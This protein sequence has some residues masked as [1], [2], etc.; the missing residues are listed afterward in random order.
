M[1]GSARPAA[2][3]S[4]MTIPLERRVSPKRPEP[5]RVE[6]AEKRT[7][8]HNWDS[9]SDS[10]DE[11]EATRRAFA[12][13]KVDTKDEKAFP[14]LGG[15]K[16]P[17]KASS[18]TKGSPQKSAWKTLPPAPARESA[19]SP[20]PPPTAS[21]SSSSVPS[22]PLTGA[23]APSW[24]SARG[25]GM[26]RGRGGPPPRGGASSYT[27]KP[28]PIQGGRKGPI[29]LAHP[30]PI[31][32]PKARRNGGNKSEPARKAEKQEKPERIRQPVRVREG[33]PLADRVRNLVLQNQADDRPKRTASS[34]S[35][36]NGGT[37]S[38]SASG[39]G[40]TSA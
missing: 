24:R 33:G 20:T 38:A 37:S 23:D 30:P 2:A 25:R 5:K 10:E 22:A 36:A 17:T 16:N 18:P 12:Q 35:T 27:S 13:L 29:G 6:R 31:S 34:T 8:H 11:E 15:S 1:P 4:A 28:H 32:P 3:S 7:E 40:T 39:G 26:P 9:E 19:S 14:P 21:S